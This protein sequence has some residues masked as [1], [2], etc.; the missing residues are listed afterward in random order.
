MVAAWTGI[1]VEALTAADAVR[2]QRL[3]ETLAV[4][5]LRLY[6]LYTERRKVLRALSL[7][8]DRCAAAGISFWTAGLL[9]A[10][11]TMVMMA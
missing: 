9:A 8:G 3:P 5:G 1:P 6:E 7:T 4:S 10:P 11:W 2:L